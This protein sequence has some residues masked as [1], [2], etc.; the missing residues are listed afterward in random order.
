MRTARE[1]DAGAT[2]SAAGRC[3]WI[4]M[5]LALIGCAGGALAQPHD[6]ASGAQPDGGGLPLI[7]ANATGVFVNDAGDV[8]TARHVVAA[9]RRL[10]VIKDAQVARAEVKAVSAE[11]DL[12]VIGSRIRPLLAA[13]FARTPAGGAQPVF[14]AG[15][16]ALRRMPDR[17]SA[18]YN[19]LARPG[20]PGARTG[21]LTLMLAATN[22]ASGSAVLDAA[23]LVIGIVTDRAAVAGGDARAVATRADAAR[24]VIAVPADAVKAFLAA[25]GVP[26]DET[27]AP[28]LEPLQSHAARAA[29]LEA[30][31]L[32]GE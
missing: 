15:Y 30:G 9:C 32:C 31:I 18:L 8:L 2:K 4:A 1:R 5:S 17:A 16:E 29:T 11:R 25:S 22:G 13:R 6:A 20:L 21:D 26:Y 14:A 7:E 24:F 12:A 27:D 23:G 3:R 10:F 28:Q 19:G